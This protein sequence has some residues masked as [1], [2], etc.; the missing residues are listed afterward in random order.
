[1]SRG[2]RAKSYV[3]LLADYK[4]LKF[5]EDIFTAVITHTAVARRHAADRGRP[6]PCRSVSKEVPH[7]AILW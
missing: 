4:K 2:L 5:F 6:W 7:D 1:M 3:L